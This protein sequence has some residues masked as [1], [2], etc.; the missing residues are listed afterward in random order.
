MR[1]G[2]VLVREEGE[3]ENEQNAR[4]IHRLSHAMHKYN[5][6]WWKM[7]MEREME[8]ERERQFVIIRNED[9]RIRSF[10]VGKQASK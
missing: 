4:G 8:R 3:E 9:T 6:L 10:Q 2:K 1:K 7:E 5:C